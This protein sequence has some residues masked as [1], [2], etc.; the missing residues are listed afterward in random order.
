MVPSIQIGDEVT[1]RGLKD[2]PVAV[3]TYN[4]VDDFCCI[5]K[6]GIT[7]HASRAA[8][9]PLKT[10]RHFDVDGFLKSLRV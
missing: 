7:F 8:L 2:R 1:L 6:D 3:V 4:T 10:G 9:N 5:N